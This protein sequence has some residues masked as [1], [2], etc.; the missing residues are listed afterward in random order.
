M[1]DT[2]HNLPNR[3]SEVRSF[4]NLSQS[5]LGKKLGVS[6]SLISHWEKGTRTP[7]ESQ[8]MALAQHMGVAL[9]YL[10]NATIRPRFQFR[11]RATSPQRDE[12]EH[13]LLD[14]SM[15]V[16][17]VDTAWRLAKK[18]PAPFSLRADFDSFDALPNITSHLRDTLKLNRRVTLDE[19]KQALSEW[20]IFVFD[21]AMPWHLSGLSFRGPFTVIF[22]NSEH[23]RTRR[24]F[25]L[26]HEFAHVVFHLGREDRQTRERL[27]AVA[28][29]ASNRD[30]LEKQAN[31]FAGE[32]LM[33]RADLQ[34]LVKNYG[35]RLREP[36]G[37]EAAAQQ[38]N[39][40]RDAMFYR[41]TQLNVFRWTEKSSYFMGSFEPPAPPVQRVSKIASQVD[42]RFRDLAL[43]LHQA[44]T[45]S[46]GKLA[47]WF[48]TPRHVVEEYLTELSSEKE[49][50]ISDD[51]IEEG[52]VVEGA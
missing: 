51:P 39:V 16:H 20:K 10:L 42:A 5:E 11:A 19:L 25:T 21:W 35:T 6:T 49:S 18:A 12:I 2:L 17:F 7:S 23:T 28:S 38:F 40:S 4:A 9:D 44:G 33:P 27:D 8:L 22:I 41:L 24:L 50:A 47:E 30:D 29:I 31:A 46:T 15:Q 13:A 26:A 43:S 1:S 37:L 52:E 45:I 34:K 32:F 36:A 3:L 14:A 48:F